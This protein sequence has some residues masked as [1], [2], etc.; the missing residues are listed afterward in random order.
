MSEEIKDIITKFAWKW[1]VLSF[2]V[3]ALCCGSIVYSICQHQNNEPQI[4]KY[5]DTF[6]VTESAIDSTLGPEY[7]LTVTL[8]EK[9]EIRCDKCGEII[10]FNVG[11]SIRNIEGVEDMNYCQDCLGEALGWLMENYDKEE[12]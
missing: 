7:T 12:N 4:Q 8:P 1:F 9:W 2:L 3:G 10:G 11:L 6:A 5:S